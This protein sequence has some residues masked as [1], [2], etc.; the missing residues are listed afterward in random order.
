MPEAET[1][2]EEQAQ[3]EQIGRIVGAA[4]VAWLCTW[5]LGAPIPVRE[6]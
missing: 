1:A 5:T 6:A 2:A 4:C 3:G